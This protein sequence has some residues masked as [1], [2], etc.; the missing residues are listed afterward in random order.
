L[1]PE[2]IIYII[3][4]YI[5]IYTHTV[6]PLGTAVLINSTGEK[7]KLSAVGLWTVM[8]KTKELTEDLRLRI[9]AA[10]KSG[11]GYKTISKCSEVPVA[12]VQSIIKKYKTFCTVKNLRGR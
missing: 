4:I 5:Y 11:T 12:T 6:E 9:M 2:D 10:H 8:A 1:C 3:Y 7:Q